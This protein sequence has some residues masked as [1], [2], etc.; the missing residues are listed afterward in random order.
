MAPILLRAAA[1]RPSTGG[2]LMSHEAS[3]PS[4]GFSD[5]LGKLGLCI[6]YRFGAGSRGRGRRD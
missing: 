2:D 5:L 1:R 6:V 3:N 4:E